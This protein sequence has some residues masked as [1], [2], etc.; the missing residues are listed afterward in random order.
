MPHN[1]TLISAVTSSGLKSVNK[2]LFTTYEFQEGEII[3]Y[4]D[5]KIIKVDDDE[6]IRENFIN[7]AENLITNGYKMKFLFILHVLG[8][9]IITHN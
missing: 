8:K 3:L 9:C 7:N 1:Y 5:K 6:R 4:Y 2:G